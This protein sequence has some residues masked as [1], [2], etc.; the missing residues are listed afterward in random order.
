MPRLSPAAMGP[1]STAE[2]NAARSTLAGPLSP[3]PQRTWQVTPPPGSSRPPNIP[4]VAPRNT[5]AP[6]SAP[7][8]PSRP[9]ATKGNGSPPGPRPPTSANGNAAP[10]PS[11]AA[12]PES[13]G[14]SWDKL[15]TDLPGS[16]IRAG[17]NPRSQRKQAAQASPRGTQAPPKSSRIALIVGL[18]SGGAL[19]LVG[20]AIWLLFLLG[21]FGGHAANNSGTTALG[22]DVVK[23]S[24][25]GGGDAATWRDAFLKVRPGGQILVRD[26]EIQGLLQI[27]RTTKPPA[28]VTIAP[29]GGQPLVWRP[30]AKFDPKDRLLNI[31]DGVEG[32]VLKNIAFDGQGQIDELVLLTGTCPGLTLQ[33]VSLEGYKKYGIRIMNCQ[34][35]EQPVKLVDVTSKNA[36]GAQ[37]AVW[38]DLLGNMS[39]KSNSYFLFKNCSFADPGVKASATGAP[40]QIKF[41]GG[42]AR[43]DK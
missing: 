32:L 37:A 21:V 2:V 39:P 18:S 38:F 43:L 35:T 17:S 12:E 27:A 20:V 33:N 16:S 26:S 40:S 29:E 19:V 6:P 22:Q 30:A 31:S 42:N 15:G 36:D 7:T 34:G 1:Q 28:N 4:P 41:E 13:E 25:K 9:P 5:P 3:A 11:P 8:Q 23:L 10:A 14:E 24:F